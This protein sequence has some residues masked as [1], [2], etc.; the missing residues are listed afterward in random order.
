MPWLADAVDRL[1]AIG[2]RD[3]LL[4]DF[5][6]AYRDSVGLYARRA[7]GLA[8]DVTSELEGAISSIIGRL[9]A[10]PTDLRGAHARVVTSSDD[11][12]DR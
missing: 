12:A 1:R 6:Q 2:V 4:R 7:H 10:D 9:H 11:P 8:A 3:D 5:H